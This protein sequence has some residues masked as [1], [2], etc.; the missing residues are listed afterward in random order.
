MRSFSDKYAVRFP[1][2]S[3]EERA[4]VTGYGVLKEGESRRAERSTVVIG[5]DARVVVSYQRVKAE[6][7]AAA[8]LA[9]LRAAA[10]AVGGAG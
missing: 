7:H 10:D 9:D 4:I 1:L 3:D 2:V 5:Q 8:V 6:G